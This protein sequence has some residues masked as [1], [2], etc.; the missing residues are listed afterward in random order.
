MKS[1][2]NDCYKTRNLLENYHHYSKTTQGIGN[3]KSIEK[4]PDED[5]YLFNFH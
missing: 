2:H 1:H 4:R 5:L 3:S